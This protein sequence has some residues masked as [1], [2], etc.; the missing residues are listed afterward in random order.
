MTHQPQRHTIWNPNAR[1]SLHRKSYAETGG[2]LN[3]IKL[4][5]KSSLFTSIHCNKLH[6]VQLANAAGTLC[7]EHKEHA[8]LPAKL[9][10]CVRREAECRQ[11]LRHFFGQLDC[12]KLSASLT[13][14]GDTA[15]LIPL[16]RRI[17]GSIRTYVNVDRT[18]DS[19]RLKLERI[20]FLISC[21]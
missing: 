15:V 20:L 16:N 5:S 21:N 14:R 17:Y 10:D 12:P 13:D 19:E 2:L 8:P 7:V 18:G 1:L 9:V 3:I 6:T 11:L 4:C